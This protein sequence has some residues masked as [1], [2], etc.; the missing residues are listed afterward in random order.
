MLAFDQR[1]ELQIEK[2]TEEAIGFA[3]EH[4]V[5][6]AKQAIQ[7]RG[8]FAVALSG[9][10]TPKAIYAELA[11]V[12]DLDWS[13][14]F[15]F[16]SDERAVPPDHKESNYHMAM[17]SFQKVPIP[18]HQIFRMQAEK[19]LLQQAKDYEAVIR[20]HLGKQ[21]FDL[22]MLGVG[23]DGH[24][25]SLFPNTHALQVEDRLVVGNDVPQLNT[26]RM[27]LTFPCINQ[28]KKIVIYALGKNKQEIVA[29][30]LEAPI[31]SAY[32]SSRIGTAERPALWVLDH[33]PSGF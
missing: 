9:G 5:H 18:L 21:L 15:L 13:N 30:V 4:F 8:F 29:K 23:E 14:V 12:K 7:Q 32:P 10:S 19:D 31:I 17:E 33:K 2:S 20:H 1:R 16:W 26:K 6:S 3:V 28:S 22:V 25:A 11:K 27:T 24:T